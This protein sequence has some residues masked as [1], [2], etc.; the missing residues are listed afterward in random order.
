MADPIP[1]RAKPRTAARSAVVVGAGMVVMLAAI[2]WYVVT[3][4]VVLALY[5]AL[6][7]A[8]RRRSR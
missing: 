6:F 3:L 1:F 7:L 2:R 8:G 5:V 4:A